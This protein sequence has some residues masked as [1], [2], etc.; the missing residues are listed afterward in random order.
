MVILEQVEPSAYVY[1]R[2]F[3][4]ILHYLHEGA[5]L[6]NDAVVPMTRMAE[7]VRSTT[8]DY[9]GEPVDSDAWAALF[10][11][12]WEDEE[13]HRRTRERRARARLLAICEVELA[14]LQT[15]HPSHA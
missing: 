3:R 4:W 10:D 9:V 8:L 15:F 5:A 12:W 2:E 14:A 6:T 13:E 1:E 11:A 7:A